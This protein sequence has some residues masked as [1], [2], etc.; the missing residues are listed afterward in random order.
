MM[1]TMGFVENGMEIVAIEIPLYCCE[2]C[3]RVEHMH[4]GHEGGMDIVAYETAPD[5]CESFHCT[6]SA[7]S[8]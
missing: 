7:L 8:L 2:D 4:H 6:I 5:H 3:F 1:A